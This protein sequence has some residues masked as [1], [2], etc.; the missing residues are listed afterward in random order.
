MS[1]DEN[2][3]HNFFL[4]SFSFIAVIGDTGPQSSIDLYE[5][6]RILDSKNIFVHFLFHKRTNTE[7][8]GKGEEED[9]RPVTGKM[10]FVEYCYQLIYFILKLLKFCLFLR[11]HFN[12]KRTRIKKFLFSNSM[13]KLNV[14]NME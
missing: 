14:K 13:H 5:K 7:E 10:L 6:L 11:F 1:F 2:T 12:S 3:K 8:E 9:P 4:L